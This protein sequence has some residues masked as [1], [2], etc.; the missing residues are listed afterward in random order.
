[1]NDLEKYL[2]KLHGLHE[3]TKKKIMW[4]GVPITMILV[5]W[6]WLSLGGFNLNPA[7][8]SQSDQEVSKFEIFKNGLKA[9]FEEAKK[10]IDDAK[11]KFL[12][13]T[14]FNIDIPKKENP[15]N[16]QNNMAEVKN[17]FENTAS[18]TINNNL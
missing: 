5:V 4:V 6:V 1:M 2:E 7:S 12:K 16:A 15:E 17:I 3:D 9:T 11:Q 14:S 18:T 8:V 13:S 10:M